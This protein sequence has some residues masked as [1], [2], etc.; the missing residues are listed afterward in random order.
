[1][2]KTLNV[3]MDDEDHERVTRKKDEMGL[4]W[5]EY[6]LLTVDDPEQLVED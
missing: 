6:L 5:E 4:T 1:M 3:V 2:V